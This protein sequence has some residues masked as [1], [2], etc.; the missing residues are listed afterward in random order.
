MTDVSFYSGPYIESV[1]KK[2]G[3]GRQKSPPVYDSR[4][5]QHLKALAQPW[6]VNLLALIPF[7]AWAVWRGK[8]L[9]ISGRQLILLAVFA[10]AFGFV[11][12][13]VVIYLR[14]ASGLL[15]GYHGTLSDIRRSSA[16]SYEHEK[17][18]S[19]FP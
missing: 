18:T 13:S 14:A 8:R 11:E 6:W 7:I 12:S 19:E 9:V 16:E 4:R 10:G 1:D 15:P 5:M 2:L 17:S 3:S